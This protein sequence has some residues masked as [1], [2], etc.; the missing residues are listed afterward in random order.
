VCVCVCDLET[1]SKR[2]TRHDVGYCATEKNL[3]LLVGVLFN[4]E[5]DG[6]SNGMGILAA[7]L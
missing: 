1:S 5:D 6:V 4:Y 7:I 3:Q 2:R